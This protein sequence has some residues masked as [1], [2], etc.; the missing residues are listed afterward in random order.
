MTPYP[1]ID[2]VTCKD[3]AIWGTVLTVEGCVYYIR[4]PILLHVFFV[5]SEPNPR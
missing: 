4:I 1:W 2:S 3:M 5:G